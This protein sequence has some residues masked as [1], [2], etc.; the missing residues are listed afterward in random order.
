L[1][2]QIILCLFL[3]FFFCEGISAQQKDTIKPVKTDTVK[4][5]IG[6]AD[7][8]HNAQDSILT[9]S[10]LIIDSV[11]KTVVD[12]IA[13]AA[14]MKMIADSTKTAREKAQIA[15]LKI[16]SKKFNGEEIL[17]YSLVALLI[18]YAIIKLL[19]PKY[20]TDLFRVYFRTTLKQ[21]QVREQL[22]QTP[23]PSLLLN[24]FFIITGGMYAA[25][26]VQHF[27]LAPKF[28]FWQLW[29]YCGIL[30]SIIY[31]MKYA[32]VWIAGWLFNRSDAA[33]AYIFIVFMTNKILGI[34]VL[35]FLVLLAFG[36]AAIY[37]F[38][39]IV[40]ITA[41]ACLFLYR[42]YLSVGIIRSQAH[43]NLLH[44]FLYL[45]AFEALPLLILFKWVMMF[46]K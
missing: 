24:G 42:F 2:R 9:D 18:F 44:F 14:R 21:T 15:S 11:K 3:F 28:G 12:S 38:A 41:V 29:L 40:S 45:F 33:S 31:M 7:T 4:P 39:L 10:T 43:V 6:F 30:L 27:K 17:F 34:I 22:L 32:G 1:H 16:T 20:F 36:T 35:P 13:N 37:P 46:L 23:L 19:F 26:L 5:E 8:I 25:F